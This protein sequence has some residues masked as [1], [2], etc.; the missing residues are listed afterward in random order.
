VVNKRKGCI[1]LTSMS[2]FVILSALAVCACLITLAIATES[3]PVD[4]TGDSPL[5]TLGTTSSPTPTPESNFNRWHYSGRAAIAIT[6]LNVKD[7]IGVWEPS[8][9]YTY[10]SLGITYGNRGDSGTMSCNPLFA[11]QLK[12]SQGVIYSP[13]LITLEPS[14]KAVELAPKAKTTGWI[15]FEIPEDDTEGLAL[16]WQPSLFS[17]TI[18]IPLK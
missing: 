4:I 11:F 10:V 1:L 14:L 7:S 15:T 17:S 2:S 18:E 3:T 6:N 8:T 12:T 5:S 9:G 13:S 16:L